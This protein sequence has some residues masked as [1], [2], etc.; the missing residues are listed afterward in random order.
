MNSVAIVD[1]RL[2]NLDSIHRAIDQCG[3]T[4]YIARDPRDLDNCNRIILPG[5]G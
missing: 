2:C 3:G 1:Y 4:P 5:V